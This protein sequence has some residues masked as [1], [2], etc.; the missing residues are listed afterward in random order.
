MGLR[1][2]TSPAGAPPAAGRLAGGSAST[3]MARSQAVLVGKRPR[4]MF[5]T[6][7]GGDVEQ[8]ISQTAEPGRKV[9]V[10]VPR[11]LPF[12]RAFVAALASGDILRTFP[13]L[14]GCYS[15]GSETV[16]ADPDSVDVTC[17]S[18]PHF[19]SKW[20]FVASS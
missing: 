11:M 6:A 12:Y 5:S 18:G 8:E 2:A 13:T 9:S 20:H 19:S 4:T 16:F 1:A 3:A 10:R 15:V 14:G 7:L 17:T